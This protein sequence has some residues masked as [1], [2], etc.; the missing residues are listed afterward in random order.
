MKRLLIAV[1]RYPEIPIA[2]VYAIIVFCLSCAIGTEFTFPTTELSIFIGFHYTSALILGGIAAICAT[3]FGS[4]QSDTTLTAITLKQLS[5]LISFNFVI[6]LH[7]HVKMWIPLI[8]PVRYDA[9]YYQIDKLFLPVLH[10]FAI[11]RES[12]ASKMGN[13]DPL[14]ANL[15]IVMFFISFICHSAYD[16]LNVRRMIMA[17]MLVQA[18]G[19]LCYLIMPAVGPFIY[20]QGLSGLATKCQGSMWHG[21]QTLIATGPRWLDQNGPRYFIG[22]LAAMPSLH[23][24]ASWVF[25]YYAYK[26]KPYLLIIYI[27]IFSWIIIEALASKWHYLIDLPVGIVVATL[28]IWMSNRIDIFCKEES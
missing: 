28:C 24:G 12:I 17:S 6:W 25:L 3:V 14:Y 23:S 21:Y 11:M 19:S 26:H 7:F 5:Y 27:P 10:A 1:K 18:I 20:E 2:G 15:F 9:L 8:N 16:R 4:K 13:I 22:G